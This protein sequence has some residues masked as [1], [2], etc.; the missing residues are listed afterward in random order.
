MKG[1][2]GLER[3]HK[4][5]AHC[6][7]A[8]RRKCEH[9]IADGRVRVNGITVKG[10]GIKIDPDRDKVEVDG[11]SINR[12]G[13]RVYIMLNKPVGYVSTVTDQFQRPTVLDL[14]SG[15]EERIYPI[16][17]LDYDS[18]GLIL[19]TNDG[20]LTYGLTHP[21]HR[22]NKTYTVIVIGKPTGGE[23]D[24]IKKGVSLDGYVTSPA[25]IRLCAERDKCTV[26][27]V[28]IYEG[29]NRQVRR[30]FEAIGYTVISL[31][32]TAIGSLSLGNL[33]IGQWRF[34]NKD[35]VKGLFSI[36]R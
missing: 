36:Y 1:E 18:E 6:G 22:V 5:M 23:I 2:L 16:G 3:L 12:I 19:L 30:M 7:V 25:D 27:R 24:S 10:T 35:E 34:L 26:Y 28:T 32:R 9:L 11:K 29:R 17:R 14:V 21:R 4:Y 33:P 15:I 20:S 31:K 8:S 13:K